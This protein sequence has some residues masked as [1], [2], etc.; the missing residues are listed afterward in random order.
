MPTASATVRS[1]RDATRAGSRRNRLYAVP[2]DRRRSA[3]L[4]VLVAALVVLLARPAS[5]QTTPDPRAG[6]QWGLIAI[7]APQA[8]ARGTGNGISVAIVSTGIAKHE[9]LDAKVTEVGAD[10]RGDETGRGT[11]LAGIVGAATGNG[12]GIAGVAPDA[13][14]RPYRAFSGTSAGDSYL[15]ALGRVR[16]AQVV[17]V[18]LPPTY[19]GNKDELRK[20]LRELGQRSAVVVGAN[21]EI[22]LDDLPVLVVAATTRDGGQAVGAVSSRGVAAPGQGILSTTPG[23]LPLPTSESYGEE[24]GTGQ[25]AAHV[26]GA[27]AI[28]RGMGASPLQAANALR[29]TATKSAN[30]D[31]GAGII[32]VPAAAAEYKP[33][34][35]PTTTTTKKAAAPPPTTAKPA[36]TTTVPPLQVPSA[37]PV[38]DTEPEELGAGQEEAVPPPNLEEFIDG[39][40]DQGGS[41]ILFGGRERPWGALTL[42][43]GLLF[44][45]GTAMSLTFRRLGADPT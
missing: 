33:L 44:G 8:W 39:T 32:D 1:A 35:A 13:R 7:K 40:T 18:D 42:G 10:E 45:V 16:D 25:A 17:L 36:A 28:L 41:T 38:F 20:A 24:T 27:V 6:E 19:T 30:A 4:V 11:H 37:G 3:P 29:S 5:A 9:D 43:F 12:K 34:P 22:A 23:S 26:A 15:E 21:P 14:L 2:V 31:L